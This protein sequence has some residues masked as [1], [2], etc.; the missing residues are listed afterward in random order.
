VIRRKLLEGFSVHTLLRLPTGIFY[1]Q[2]VNASVLFFDRKRRRQKKT[3]NRLW[4]YDL[5]TEKR[6]SLAG[7]RLER[8]DLDEFVV[9]YHAENRALREESWSAK[10]AG[11][12]WRSF[13]HEEILEGDK[14]S[15]DV[16]WLDKAPKEGE[17]GPK[18]LEDISDG[19]MRD[20]QLA[21][22]RISELSSGS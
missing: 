4:V 2:S 8:S 1:A 18:A 20:L 15:M 13:S 19:I 17:R 22:Q 3:E 14:A 12:R 21:M 6:F 10:N 7:N 11:G 9:C 5:R 16:L